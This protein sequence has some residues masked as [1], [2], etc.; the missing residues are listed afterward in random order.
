MAKK[1][2]T[3]KQKLRKI[4][5]AS[6]KKMDAAKKGVKDT[7]N[8][9]RYNKWLFI[10]ETILLVGVIDEYFETVIMGL[11][12]SIYVHILLLMLSIG[13]L[14]SL[15]LRFIEPVAKGGIIWIVRLNNNK[16]LRAVV[17]ILILS[18]LYYLYARVFFD[19][20]V[21]LS[22]NIGLNAS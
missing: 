13:I 16:I 7:L 12:Q 4:K 19:T 21:S 17:H 11:N 3:M 9:N 1:K 15:A 14:F 20:S 6:T 5:N 10:F 8:I 2:P 18:V 22:F